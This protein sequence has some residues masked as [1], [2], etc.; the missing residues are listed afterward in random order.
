MWLSWRSMKS[1]SSEHTARQMLATSRVGTKD[2]V[3][4]LS[5]SGSD[6]KPGGRV[7]A[8]L[9]TGSGEA[10]GGAWIWQHGKVSEPEPVVDGAGAVVSFEALERLW[11]SWMFVSRSQWAG[12]AMGPS[13]SGAST[14]EEIWCQSVSHGGAGSPDGVFWVGE[15]MT[16]CV[17]AISMSMEDVYDMGCIVLSIT[18]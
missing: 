6:K 9:E 4:A 1:R 5:S 8:L 18:T 2:R 3:C 15:S 10:N 17:G 13:L 12:R 7:A 16:V 14:V 11:R